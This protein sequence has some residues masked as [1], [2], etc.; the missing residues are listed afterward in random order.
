MRCRLA[1]S[2]SNEST[3]GTRG[4][5]SV[6]LGTRSAVLG[7]IVT[8][9]SAATLTFFSG[10]FE[11]EFEAVLRFRLV[12]VAVSLGI[13]ASP[14]EERVVGI[15]YAIVLSNNRMYC[16]EIRDQGLGQENQPVL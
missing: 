15:L 1:S 6:P 11:G 4:L 14:L 13:G 16:G 10:D 12:T 5:V 3:A 9:V 8:A 2:K 7:G